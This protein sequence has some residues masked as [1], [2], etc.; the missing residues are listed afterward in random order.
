MAVELIGS[1]GLL[2]LDQSAEPL[3]P[4]EEVQITILL[5]QLSRQGLTIIQV[6]QRARSA[7]LSDKVIILAPGGLLAWF[8]PANEAFTHFQTLIPRGVAKDLFALKEAIE[9]LANP[10]QDQGTEW[11]KRFKAHQAYQKYVDDPLNNRYPDLLLQTRPLL[12]LR[13]RNS[14]QEKLPPPIIPRANVAQKLI[15]LIRRNTRLLWRDK[16][17]FSLLAIPPL[18]ASIDFVLSSILRSQPER[19]PIIFGVLVF[20]V[21]LTSASLVQNEISKEKIVYRYEN[22]TRTLLLPYILSKVWL[23]GILA[24][25]QALVWTTIHFLATGM[26]AAPQALIPYGVALFLIAFTGGMLGLIVSAISKKA[27]TTTNWLLLLT[28]PQ[29]ILSGAI[30][31]VENLSFPLNILA[32]INPSRYG[33][34]ALL[35]SSGFKEGISAIPISHW[36][37][38][39][40][41][42][43]GLIVF[44]VGIQRR[45]E[46]ARI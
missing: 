13:L 10:Q 7:G 20:L 19:A 17:A 39:V 4:F 38:F 12:R 44:L 42:S 33:L 36:F 2:L 8:G 3:T 32:G 30:L 5:R 29:L 25:Y 41:I 31:P 14:S 23:V 27:T 15:L 9:L 34:D 46:N 1:P 26:A 24:I 22:R 16:T 28:V 18:I 35:I 11:A 45:A 6:D 37:A 40:I 43:V 21:L